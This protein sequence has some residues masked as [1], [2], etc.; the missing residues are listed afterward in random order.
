VEHEIQEMVRQRTYQIIAG[1]PDCNDANT[2]R[3]DPMV[4]AVCDRLPDSEEELSSQPTLSR[5]ENR[6]TRRDVWRLS[7][8]LVKRYVRR[9]KKRKA[10][11]IVL[12]VDATEDP[13]HGQQEF[14]FYHG[15]FRRHVYHPLLIFDGD[16]GDLVCAVLR[17]GNRG[18]GASVVAILRRV[19]QAVRRQLGRAVEIEIRADCGFAAPPLYEFCEAEGLRYVIGICRNC[20]LESGAEKL[21]QSARKSFEEEQV[22]QRCFDEFS[23]AAK[24]WDRRRRIIAK[25]EVNTMGINRRFVV[26]NRQDLKPQALY[27]HYTDRGESENFIKMFKNDLA[28]D[29]LSCHRFLANQFRLLLHAMAYQMFLSLRDYLYGTLWQKLQ[30]ETLRRRCLKIGAQV[31][32][33]TRK[34]WVRLSSSFPEQETFFLV[35]TRLQAA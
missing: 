27:D 15:Y 24:S 31:R 13:T 34:I 12:D 16:S 11:K 18:A 6:V 3:S 14:S 29:R 7:H 4:K 26:T 25:V 9:L 23:Y 2:L 19:V 8:W 21:L 35:L 33:T 32:Q 10:P 20:K 1:Y 28:M 17:P 30:V 22:A 5:L